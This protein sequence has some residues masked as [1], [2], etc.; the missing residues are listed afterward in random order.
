MGSSEEGVLFVP[1][2]GRADAT[3]GPRAEIS[4][5]PLGVGSAGAVGGSPGPKGEALGRR[6]GG[7]GGPW[8]EERRRGCCGDR[9]SA[10]AETHP[11]P[12][13]QSLRPGLMR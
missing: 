2:L 7:P 3:Q 5:P 13:G 11:R 4:T 10:V 8:G 12:H 6:R 9:R 1:C